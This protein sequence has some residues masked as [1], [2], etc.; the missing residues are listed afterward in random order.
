LH[1]EHHRWYS[2]SLGR[3]MEMLVFGHGGTKVLAFPTR[4]GRYYDY[5]GFGTI[6]GARDRIE[7]GHLQFFCVD[8]VDAESFY[9][10]T[11]PPVERIRRH[12][13]YERYLINEVM[14]FI[15]WKNPA[16][17]LILLGCSLG[18]YHAVNLAF[19][20]P[21]LAVKVV[22]L[23]GRYDLTEPLADFRGLLDGYYDDDVYF[24]M[25]S[26]YIPNLECPDELEALR[27][28]HICLV[29]GRDDPFLPNNECLSRHLWAK[30]IGHEFHLWEGR[31]HKAAY[32]REMLRLYL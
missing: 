4:A 9:S 23:S 3:D 13:D 28:L 20:H 15:Q 30:G 26:H 17:P 5:E 16:A 32:W 7:A 25:P 22:G 27:R 21:R 12:I 2:P 8:S 11:C 14:P 31:A 10:T 1:R 24:H 18:A 19:R 29:V 6:E